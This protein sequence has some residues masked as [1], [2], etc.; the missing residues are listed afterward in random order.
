MPWRRQR[1]P[2][3]SYRRWYVK[4]VQVSVSCLYTTPIMNLVT[5]EERVR[6]LERVGAHLT[7]LDATVDSQAIAARVAAL[8]LRVDY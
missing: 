5:H 7:A 1:H 6:K 8:L 2:P 4:H 3:V